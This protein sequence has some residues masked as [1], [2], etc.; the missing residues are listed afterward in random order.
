MTILKLVQE[1]NALA[2]LVL[3]YKKIGELEIAVKT[4]MPEFK[5]LKTSIINKLGLRAK[6]SAYKD[7][8]FMTLQRFQH[9]HP[10]LKLDVIIT[11]RSY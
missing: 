6:E 3:D 2:T 4:S 1:N 7:F 11:K 5:D 10:E 8:L 9:Q